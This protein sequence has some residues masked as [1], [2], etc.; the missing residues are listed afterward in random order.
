[1]R[2]RGRSSKHQVRQ[3]QQAVQALAQAC[4]ETKPM[5][6]DLPIRPTRPTRKGL[7]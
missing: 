2:V 1:M 7:K 6:D 4:G 3:N 5:G